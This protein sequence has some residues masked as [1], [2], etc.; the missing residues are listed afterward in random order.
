MT[1]VQPGSTAAWTFRLDTARG[2]GFG[3]PEARRRY[4]K[5]AESCAAPFAAQRKLVQQLCPKWGGDFKAVREF[6]RECLTQTPDGGICGAVVGEGY[7]EARFDYDHGHVNAAEIREDLDVASA[8][9]LHAD[10]QPQHGWVAAHSLLAA[11]FVVQLD[12]DAARPHFAALGNTFSSYP[13]QMF[14]FS[15]AAAFRKARYAALGR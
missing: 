9:I 1:A 14:D 13:W 8:R 5:A 7:L 12:K 6:T 3:L 10:F 2:L 15:D 11:S 4:A